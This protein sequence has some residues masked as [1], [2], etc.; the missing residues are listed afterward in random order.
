MEKSN[1]DK[2]IKDTYK[3]YSD[4]IKGIGDIEIPNVEIAMSKFHNDINKKTNKTSLKKKVAIAA[5]F[6][7]IFFVSTLISSLPEVKASKFTLTKIIDHLRG[8]VR[9]F[10]LNTT[11]DNES[12]PTDNN[13]FNNST[14]IDK[15]VSFDEAQNEVPFKILKPTYLPDGYKLDTIMLTVALSDSYTVR[16]TYVDDDGNRIK[17]YQST[18]SDNTSE[19]TSVNSNNRVE[20]ININN[21]KI[22]LV[23]DDAN[24]TNVFG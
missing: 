4:E 6:L 21:L 13:A 18:I 23:S 10:K 19:T 24:F 14:Q 17:F 16:Q 1:F 8:S 12:A 20:D 11:A 15:L 3:E 2:I 5:S 7:I 9:D 22:K